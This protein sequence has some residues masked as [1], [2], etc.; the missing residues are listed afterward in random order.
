MEKRLELRQP[1][2]ATVFAR[3]ISWIFH[4]LFIP[5][6]VMAFILYVH[7]YAFAGYD[8]KIKFFRFLSVAFSTALLPAFSVFLLWRLEF[9][10]SIFLRTQKERIIP[11]VITMVYYFWV[12]YVFNN[13]P[14]IPRMVITFLLGVFIAVCI[15]WMANIAHKISMH[16]TGVGGAA[17]FLL[18]QAFQD[19]SIS[20]TYVSAAIVVAGLVCTAR[21]ILG[22]HTRWEVYAGLLAGASAQ[23]L[24]VWFA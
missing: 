6:Y 3:M 13:L 11:Y 7:P 22:G 4:P 15:A 23:V 18:L 8:D 21:L 24:A 10:D 14:D 1:L 2:A 20:G 19:A 12:W 17:M 5:S 16:A 9:T